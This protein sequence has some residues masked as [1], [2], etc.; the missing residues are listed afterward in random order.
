MLSPGWVM[1]PLETLPTPV[2]HF[3]LA[4][5]TTKLSSSINASLLG[6]RESHL[7]CD[8]LVW[9]RGAGIDNARAP[10]QTLHTYIITYLHCIALQ[11]GSVRAAEIYLNSTIVSLL[12]VSLVF[13]S[14]II[15][16]NLYCS[17]IRNIRK[18]LMGEFDEH[19]PLVRRKCNEINM[20]VGCESVGRNCLVQAREQWPVLA[21]TV[22]NHRVI[23]NVSTSH[24]AVGLTNQAL[25]RGGS[26]RVQN[27]LFNYE[28]IKGG[29]ICSEQKLVSFLK[30]IWYFT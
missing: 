4:S 22:L 1:V 21:N 5:H 8:E 18:N 20:K 17:E 10:T 14:S 25:L 24:P 19:K 9:A 13:F 15:T 27:V 11:H 7:I 30:C 26:W 23:Q 29:L 28:E 2:I 3:P 6:A 12:V 16:R